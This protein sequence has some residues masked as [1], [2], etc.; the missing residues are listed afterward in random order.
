MFIDL[1]IVLKAFTRLSIQA[2]FHKTT[3]IILP[4]IDFTLK[5]LF[6]LCQGELRV[7]LVPKVNVG[8][9]MMYGNSINFDNRVLFRVSWDVYFSVFFSSQ[10]WSFWKSLVNLKRWMKF[11]FSSFSFPRNANSWRLRN[12]MHS[13]FLIRQIAALPGLKMLF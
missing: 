7:K 10:V 5:W 12:C 3:S 6:L 1:E 2:L 13:I 9:K 4:S 8:I 11:E